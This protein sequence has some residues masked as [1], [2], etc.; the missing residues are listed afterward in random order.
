LSRLKKFVLQIALFF[1]IFILIIAIKNN[2]SKKKNLL[3][4]IKVYLI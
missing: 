1:A 4:T 3:D 2:F